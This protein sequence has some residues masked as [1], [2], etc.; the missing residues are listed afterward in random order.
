MRLLHEWNS[1][2]G[3]KFSL[4]G[5]RLETELGCDRRVVLEAVGPD[6]VTHLSTDKNPTAL[7]QGG[8]VAPP[9]SPT[10]SVSAYVQLWPSHRFSW[11]P[12]RFLHQDGGV[13]ATG[14]CVGK[15]SGTCVQGG[16]R[17]G[18]YEREGA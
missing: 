4:K 9:P 17:A 5:W 6:H 18:D 3:K 14:V 8:A 10:T 11:P 13:R 1:S 16:G 15:C 12:P 7:V 2:T